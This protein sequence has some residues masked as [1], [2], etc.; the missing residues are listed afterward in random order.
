MKWSVAKG[1]GVRCAVTDSPTDAFDTGSAG[2]ILCT[3]PLSFGLVKTEIKKRY[4]GQ[5]EHEAT[6]NHTKEGKYRCREVIRPQKRY[7][8][9]GVNTP[10]WWTRHRC[11]YE[12]VSCKEVIQY[13]FKHF[14]VSTLLW[15]AVQC[16]VTCSIGTGA[17]D[18]GLQFSKQCLKLFVG[19]LLRI[20]NSLCDW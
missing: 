7:S 14:S 1:L 11:N 6:Q 12:K 10:R 4:R 2:W 8:S 16:S 5:Q 20:D 13:T 19:L 17:A 9:L 15:E 18:R 3:T